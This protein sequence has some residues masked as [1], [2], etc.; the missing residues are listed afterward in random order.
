MCTCQLTFVLAST[1]G[2]HAVDLIVVFLYMTGILLAGW[3]FSR[4]QKETQQFFVGGRSMPWM[5]VGLSII[6]TMLSTLT[7][8]AAPGE[9][10]QHGPALALGWLSIP[11]TFVIVNWLWIPFFMKLK[12]T[13]VYEYLEP[14]FGLA[15][16]WVAV[17]L[18]VFVLR[19][20]WMAM[21]VLTASIAVAHITGPIAQ[22]S[23]PWHPGINQWTVTVLLSVGLLATVYTMLG[24][25]KAV[26][27]TDVAQFVALVAGI[28]F[29][30]IFVT[31][32]T[33]TGP[34][35]WW[36][37]L[38]ENSNSGKGFPAWFSFDPTERNVILFTVLNTTFWY[39]CTFVADQVAVQRYL[40]TSSVKAARLGNV[41]NFIGDFVVMTLLALCGMALLTFYLDPAQQTEIVAGITD[42][43]HPDVADDV[44]PHFIAYGLPVGISGLVIAALFAVAMSSLDSG[45]NSVAAV[46]TVDIA[47]RRNPDMTEPAALRLARKLSLIV[48]VTCTATAYVMYLLPSD[49]NIIG[50]AARTF[51]LALGPLGIMFIAG[52]FFR[53]VGQ[54]A[55][56]VGVAGSLLIAVITAWY[57]E[58][59]WLF[60]FTSYESFEVT[61][62]NM[63]GP[64]PFL[65]TP[66]ATVGGLLIAL[67]ASF[68]WPNT[69][70][71]TE[72]Y[73]W[74]SIVNRPETDQ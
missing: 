71:Q 25:I 24:G 67:V 62:A 22:Q 48:G 23:L 28:I 4:N 42:P 57:V 32:E 20:L 43:R 41:V 14:R 15:T 66:F 18:F 10:I 69:N 9:L 2:L 70:P 5:A 65:I 11:I 40:T 7:Y 60:G 34:V 59:A 72:Q 27:W 3:Y 35:Q 19:L 63:N 56:L 61:Q 31:I 33:S 58:L 13:S 36:Q 53:R 1:G 29:T 68:F 8:L 46:F 74:R 47:R 45:I 26:I 49:Y 17:A 12:V 50:V 38:V 55:I 51:N 52:L 30:L 44:F 16:R 54:R 37:N 6:A 21:I 39:T 73:L 64:S